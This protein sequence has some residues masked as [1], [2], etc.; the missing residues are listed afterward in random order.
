MVLPQIVL[1]EPQI[2]QNTGNLARCTAANNTHLHLIEPLGFDISQKQ[3]KRA[4]LDYWPEAQVSTHSAWEQFLESQ[5][6]ERK[7]LWFFSTKAE[8][9]YWD[10]KFSSNDYLV[11]G[12]EGGGLNESFHNQY[13][14]RLLRIPISNP[15][16]RSLNLANAVAVALYEAKRQLGA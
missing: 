16:V 12:S 2:P 5:E 6:I 14:D 3:V 8:T 4:G 7:H 11:F 10:V 9:L 13:S 1:V 15:N